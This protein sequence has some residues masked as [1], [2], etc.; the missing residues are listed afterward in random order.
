MEK[1]CVTLSEA[2]EANLNEDKR[3][4]KQSP[5]VEVYVTSNEATENNLHNT[6]VY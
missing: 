6:K 5:F 4:L 3:I 2:S 1:T